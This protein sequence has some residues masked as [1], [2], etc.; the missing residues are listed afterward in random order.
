MER[1]RI[2]SIIESFLFVAGE[3][4]TLNRM[5]DLISEATRSEVRTALEELTRKCDE[6]GRGIKIVEV[7][8][9]H[10]FQTHPENAQWV[11]RLMQTKPIRL[12][13]ASL[14]TLAIVAYKQPVT[15]PEV[16]EVRGVDSG[17]VLKTLLEYGFVKIAGRK[18]VPGKPLIY[19]TDRK[20]MEFFRL[21]TLAELPTMKE[22]E[23]IQEER[24]AE[25]VEQGDLPLDDPGDQAVQGEEA[26]PASEVEDGAGEAGPGDNGEAADVGEEPGG[27]EEGPEDS[28]EATGNQ[29]GES[30]ETEDVPED[31]E[32]SK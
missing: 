32:D 14:E 10:Q 31:S 21:K 23:E 3:P 17:G 4:V 27:P 22:L 25:S 11:G 20:F 5:C 2:E 9:G 7:A 24:L 29:E 19:A 13:R 28:E 16:E 15:K 26:G 8:G 30:E 1:E 6:D 18:D 12:S